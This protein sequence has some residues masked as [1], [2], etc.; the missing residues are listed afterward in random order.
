M[1][2]AGLVAFVRRHRWAV[3]STVSPEGAPQAAVVGIAVSD[4][5]ELVFDTLGSTRKARNLRRDGRV[6]VVVGW[7]EERTLQIDGVAD[8]PAGEEL[9]AL[10]RV[11]F[12]AFPDG[13]TRLGWPGITHVRVQ[14]RWLRYSDFSGREPVIF[15]TAI[16]GLV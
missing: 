16:S 13:P 15:E 6:A 5:F 14:P 4:G 8:E 1:T 10:R 9:D 3:V 2:R 7:D 12:A 11:Y